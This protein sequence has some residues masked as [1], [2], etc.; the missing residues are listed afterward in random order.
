M[1]FTHLH[2]S[3]FVESGT[4]TAQR[5]QIPR[6]IGIRN[7]SSPEKRIRNPECRIQYLESRIH[8]LE[9]RIQGIL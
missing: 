5:T 4:I 2:G 1:I 6:T 3:F 7:P 9:S 8:G